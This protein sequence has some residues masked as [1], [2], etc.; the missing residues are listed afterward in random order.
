MDH[1]TRTTKKY[2]ILYLVIIYSGKKFVRRHSKVKYLTQYDNDNEKH[3][4]GL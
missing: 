3:V 4:K 2:S 1:G